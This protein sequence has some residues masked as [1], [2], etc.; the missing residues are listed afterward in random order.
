MIASE[1]AVGGG[2]CSICKEKSSLWWAK[3]IRSHSSQIT[4]LCA[5]HAA[6]L[7]SETLAMHENSLRVDIHACFP[8]RIID[9]LLKKWLWFVVPSTPA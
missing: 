4:W 8:Y 3:A 9:E 6:N 1:D 5:K 2:G 7:W